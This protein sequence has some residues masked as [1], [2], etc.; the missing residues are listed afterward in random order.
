MSPSKRRDS[1]GQPEYSGASSHGSRSQTVGLEAELSQLLVTKLL[2][3]Q[4]WLSAISIPGGF[5]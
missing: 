5:K 1:A 3:N 4:E 2:P